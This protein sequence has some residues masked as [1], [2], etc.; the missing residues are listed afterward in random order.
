MAEKGV[1][2]GGGIKYIRARNI[3]QKESTSSCFRPGHSAN[4]S[5]H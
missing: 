5:R 1:R 3:H 2:G 4:R